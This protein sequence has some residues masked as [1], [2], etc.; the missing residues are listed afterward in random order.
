VQP[1]PELGLYTVMEAP[2]GAD[3]ALA[4]G[5]LAVV[6]PPRRATRVPLAPGRVR[7]SGRYE[8]TPR[9]LAFFAGAPAFRAVQ[10]SRPSL[11]IAG[12]RDRLPALFSLRAMVPLGGRWSAALE[13]AGGLNLSGSIH[14]GTH[15][16]FRGGW[17]LADESACLLPPIR[18]GDRV[19]GTFSMRHLASGILEAG[20]AASAGAGRD[21]LLEMVRSA[22]SG[23]TYP[24][25]AFTAH[26]PVRLV[27]VGEVEALA[28]DVLAPGGPVVPAMAGM[29]CF[30][31]FHLPYAPRARE[32][33]ER[34]SGTD[35]QHSRPEA[36]PTAG[37]ASPG[38]PG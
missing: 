14:N 32:R 33:S 37:P 11:E 16:D 6:L 27:V 35:L 30:G 21:V 13:P 23:A 4:D 36:G 22:V 19:Q 7:V 15:R 18:A 17:L 10:G 8:G 24:Q 28:A 34:P 9:E 2:A 38:R 5:I 12:V 1:G 26:S 29:R 25:E 20:A 3:V 31:S